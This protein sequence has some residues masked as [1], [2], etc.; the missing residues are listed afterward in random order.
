L[1]PWVVL[2]LAAACHQRAGV[3]EAAVGGAPVTVERPA[4]VDRPPLNEPV[5]LSSLDAYRFPANDPSLD[6]LFRGVPNINPNTV[7][8]DVETM[9]FLDPSERSSYPLIELNGEALQYTR[10]VPGAGNRLI[11][12]VTDPHLI[13]RRNQVT[14]VWTGN[15]TATRTANPL[16]FLST[17]I[18][19]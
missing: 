4:S 5:E 9:A 11:A 3:P 13:G 7:V 8:I 18:Q 16:H 19:N 17:E 12:V 1:V 6:R 15:R 2:A 14:V 10:V